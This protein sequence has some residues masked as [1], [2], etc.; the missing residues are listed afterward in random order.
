MSRLAGKKA[1]VTGGGIGIG[2]RIVADLAREGA[3]VAFTYLTHAPDP[4]FLDALAATNAPPALSMQLDVTD[5]AAV[6][7]GVA[8]AAGKL[9]GLDI[10]VNNA[11]GLIGRVPLAEMSTEHWRTVMAVNLDSTFMVTREA[12]KFMHPGGRIVNVSSVAGQNGGSDGSGAYAAAKAGIFG[13][14][15]SLAKELAPKQ[16]TVNALAPG[17]ILDTPF[18]ETFSTPERQRATIDAIPLA[19]AGYPDDVSGP[20]LW[21]CSEESAFVTGTVVDING[22]A[23]FT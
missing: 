16:I 12:I 10:L 17:L 13:Y 22:G 6:I 3:Q 2:R 19:R 18:H 23:Y 9:G 8:D 1:L 21:L 20:V 4:E 15:R 5:E 11:G 14:T 7:D